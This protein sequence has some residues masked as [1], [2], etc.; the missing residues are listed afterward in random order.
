MNVHQAR[1]YGCG[2][3][4]LQMRSEDRMPRLRKRQD[5]GHEVAK[6]LGTGTLAEIQVRLK[7][8]LCGSKEAKLAV[9]SPPA[10]RH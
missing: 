5:T 9:L 10:P 4:A 6:Q 3:S 8:S 1:P 7:C 2:S